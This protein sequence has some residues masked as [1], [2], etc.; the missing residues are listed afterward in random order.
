MIKLLDIETIKKFSQL[1]RF[2][3][4]SERKV[5]TVFMEFN[6]SRQPFVDIKIP[7]EELLKSINEKPEKEH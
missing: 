6:G 7:G 5:G 4:N 3:I 1:V 2:I